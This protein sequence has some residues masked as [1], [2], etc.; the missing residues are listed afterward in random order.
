MTEG[1]PIAAAAVSSVL[2]GTGLRVASRRYKIPPSTLSRLITK[3][4]A[5]APKKENGRPPR[6]TVEEE[7][8]I[9]DSVHEF[10]MFGA[11]LNRCLLIDLTR[12]LCSGTGNSCTPSGAE[13]GL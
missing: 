10:T 7:K 8:T 11:P 1:D 12:L 6:L 9:L 3:E 13:W 5:G 2:G 4:K